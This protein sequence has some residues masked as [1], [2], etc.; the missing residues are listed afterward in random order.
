[1]IVEYGKVTIDVKEHKI[2]SHYPKGY[3]AG[4]TVSLNGKTR[5]LRGVARIPGKDIESVWV[6]D[7]DGN[8]IPVDPASLT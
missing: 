6:Q 1:M 2:S 5:T 3:Q 8:V 4:N 7:P